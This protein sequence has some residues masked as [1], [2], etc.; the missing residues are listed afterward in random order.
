MND[1]YTLKGLKELHEKFERYLATSNP[2]IYKEYLHKP[3]NT[4][5]LIDLAPY[6]EDFIAQT[7]EVESELAALRQRYNDLS[8]M[9][10]FKRQYIVRKALRKFTKEQA[11]Q[12]DGNLLRAQ[13]PFEF[14]E[15]NFAINV[16]NGVAHEIADQYIAWACLSEAGRAYHKD[17]FLFRLPRKYTDACLIDNQMIDGKICAIDSDLR[18]RDGFDLTD[19]GKSAGYVSDQANYCIWCHDRNKDSCSKGME[20]KSGCPL[21]QKISEMNQL[22]ANGHVLG[23]LAVIAI[24]NPLVAATGYRICNDCMKA[25]IFQ[26]QDPVDIPSIESSILI[27]VL[28]L[29]WGFEI[30]SLLTRW[31][32]LN[33]ARPLPKDNTNKTVLVSGIGPAGFNLSHH[34]I[35]D[36]HNVIA[37]DGL[38]IEPLEVHVLIKDVTTLFDPL[39]ERISYGF[40]G[41]AEYGITAR[42]DKNFLKIVRLLLQ[43]RAN[44][45]MYGGVRLGSTITIDEAF[46]LGIDHVAICHGA[47]KP[48]FIPV[49]NF[50]AKGMRMASDFLMALQL[51][52]A[53]KK[54]SLANLQIRLPIVVIG[55][56]L[57]AVDS[58]TEALAYYPVQVKKFYQRYDKKLQLS[59]EDQ[60]IANEFI[61]HAIALREERQKPNPDIIG[62]LRKWG[63]ATIAYRK[64]MQESPAYRLNHEELAKALEEG[65]YFKEQVNVQDIALD[66]F[67]HVSGI[68]DEDSYLEAKTILVA[69]G[70]QNNT[71]VPPR[72]NVSFYGDANP[73]FAGNVVKAMASAK[74]GYPVI[75]K[76]LE[77]R[78]PG[79]PQ[80]II[81]KLDFA[82]TIKEVNVLADNII[83]VV[84][85][86]PRAARKFKPGQFYRFQNYETLAPVKNGARL[87]MEGIALTGASVDVEA[88]TISLI[89]LEMGGSSDIC[90]LLKPGEPVVLMG[91]TGSPSEIV[92][93]KTV[94]LAG[95]GLGNAVL[96]SIGQALRQN[97]CHVIYFAAYRDA[98]DVFK[99]GEIEK[100][101]DQI[102]WCIE[103][104]DFTPGRPQDI[105]YKGNIVDAMKAHRFD[106]I[107]HM[108]VIGSDRMMKAV[109]NIRPDL[110]KNVKALASINSPMQCMMKEICA[111]CLQKHHDP[112]TGKEYFVFSCVN[113]DQDMNTVDFEMLSSRLGQNS[114][115]EKVTA[116]W[117]R[118][119]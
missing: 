50:L 83:E 112:Q 94:L 12:F 99:R 35:Q 10:T 114:L 106:N 45:N 38:K 40:G 6:V 98:K 88:G 4:N 61:E 104:G 89:V 44:F 80:A 42:W 36:G 116:N 77:A 8:S 107:E 14:S 5:F 43:R 19:A 49:N 18:Q 37:I 39:S 96:F 113:Q 69:A 54:D 87:A 110:F 26:K 2:V 16:A 72:D 76:L 71:A 103:N 57:T 3:E 20:D 62:L 47:G 118:R 48:N 24:D 111:Q 91:P 115:S 9:I 70:T 52:G 1:F 90:R 68:I 55:A 117:L 59:E 30:Y 7:F 58:A 84:V 17:G 25:C 27:D 119:D 79:N 100:A 13:L 97:G 81:D 60:A 66:K 74:H 109:N 41:V 78:A 73:Q 29:P 63:G 51:T 85:H 105:L 22:R 95:G 101:A 65:I 21:D 56:G 23:A 86:A 75:S 108:L 31:N 82:A 53:A 92:K 64:S 93:N 46:E 32:P 67:G 33:F 34:L 102:I 15:E 28:N 11:E